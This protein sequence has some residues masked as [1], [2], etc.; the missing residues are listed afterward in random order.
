MNNRW[1]RHDEIM[2]K[3]FANMETFQKFFWIVWV[4][5]AVLG[6]GII[7]VMIWAV[8]RLVLKYG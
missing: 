6:L 8:I 5:G 2:D 4:I 3:H 1:K 7:G